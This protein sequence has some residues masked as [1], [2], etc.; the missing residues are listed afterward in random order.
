M[1]RWLGVATAAIVAS[2]LTGCG[3]EHA[4]SSAVSSSAG[5][6]R[7]PV[8]MSPTG[9]PARTPDLAS[10]PSRTP[11]AFGC[12]GDNT[13]PYDDPKPND[14][15]RLPESF[16]PAAAYL[17][18]DQQRPYPGDGVWVVTVEQR[19]QGDLQ[20]LR[21]ALLR[22]DTPAPSATP[23][24][25]VACAAT[26]VIRPTLSLVSSAGQI[27]RPRAPVDFCHD[28]LPAVDNAIQQLRR[29]TVSVVKSDRLETQAKVDA[30]HKAVAQGCTPLTKDD[31]SHGLVPSH[32]SPGGTLG[33]P[34][35]MLT[36]CRYRAVP[37]NPPEATFVGARRLTPAQTRRLL[38]A[39]S[40]PGQ[41]GGAAGRTRGRGAGHADSDAARRDRARWLLKGGPGVAG[42]H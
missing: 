12:N 22:P 9:V 13:T 41:P 1:S 10:E 4:G 30:D 18:F 23:G 2:L 15:P 3:P 27:L 5:R 34:V 32:L 29:V 42:A 11:A 7:P 31:F 25:T 38:A 17:C 37:A 28:Q 20:P 35:T 40:L 19:L 14:G 16:L 33:Y 26:L 21:Q 39:I 24:M 36:L 8:A 6:A